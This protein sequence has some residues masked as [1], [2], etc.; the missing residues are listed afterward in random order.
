MT[1]NQIIL[2]TVTAA[3]AAKAQAANQPAW[4]RAIEKAAEQLI[5]N[6]YICEHDGGLLMLSYSGETYHANGA[7]QCRAYANG[8]P[9]WHRAAAQLVKR[10]REAEAAQKAAPAPAVELEKATVAFSSRAQLIADI[11]AGW[12]R[13]R[14]F[15]SYAIGLHQHFGV[16]RLED[17]PTGG[18]RRVL[19]ALTPNKTPPPV[20]PRP[21]IIT[22]RKA[23][24]ACTKRRRTVG[25]DG[26]WIKRRVGQ[27]VD[28]WEA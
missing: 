3:A 24:D 9:C 2:E 14:P 12:Q 8:R 19:A 7:C 16:T 18:L 13:I 22:Q 10:Y 20:Q 4:V 11:K 6:P 5:T 23:L 27:A 26:W 21:P 1:L 28:G 17:V 25:L 15:A